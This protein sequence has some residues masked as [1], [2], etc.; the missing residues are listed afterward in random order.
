MFLYLP[1]RLGHP[2]DQLC[3][4]LCQLNIN[5]RRILSIHYLDHHLVAF[6]IHNDYEFELRSQLKKFKILVQDD[7]DPLDPSNLCDPNYDSWDKAD[8]ACDAR[9][10]FIFRTLRA[11]GHLKGAAKQAVASFFAK[12]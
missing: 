5:T 11:L 4:R 12:G 10:L 7:Y 8:K 3:S 1:L 6:L 9:G 2:I